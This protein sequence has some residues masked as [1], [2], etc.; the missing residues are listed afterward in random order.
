MQ[1]GTLNM[2]EVIYRLVHLRTER[3]KSRDSL[4]VFIFPIST[5][6]LNS[7]LQ[8]SLALLRHTA[9]FHDLPDSSDSAE[10]KSAC[11]II[12]VML[13]MSKSGRSPSSDIS[14]YSSIACGVR[15][16]VSD[17]YLI[18]AGTLSLTLTLQGCATWQ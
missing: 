4:R 12:F 9:F 15:R 10:T 5:A 13:E 8:K 11:V 16:C 1:K 18:S 6:S 7:D 14:L 17:A 3:H 2:A